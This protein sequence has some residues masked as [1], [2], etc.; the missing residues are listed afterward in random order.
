MTAPTA[1][2]E[3]YRRDLELVLNALEFYRLAVGEGISLQNEDEHW[4]DPEMVF[5]EYFEA[6]NLPDEDGNYDRIPKRIYD[7]LVTA[8]NP[9]PSHISP[10]QNEDKGARSSLSVSR[11]DL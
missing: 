9:S 3:Q 11:G 4:N 5:A 2:V 7:R 6:S 10:A 8:T 1:S